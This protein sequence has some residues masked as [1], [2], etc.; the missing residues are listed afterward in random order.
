MQKILAESALIA[1]TLASQ[2]TLKQAS[3]SFALNVTISDYMP[4][5]YLGAGENN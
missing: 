2:Q 1:T 3:T 4:N 5:V